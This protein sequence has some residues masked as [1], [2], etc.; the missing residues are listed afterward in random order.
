[1]KLQID[2]ELRELRLE[3]RVI[4]LYSDEAFSLLSDLWVSTG[5]NQR[6][7][8]TF[9]WLGVP[10]IQLP[11]DVIRYQ[12]VLY[13][14]RPDVVIE[15]GIA[16]GGSAILSASLLKL[17]GRGRVIAIDIDIRPQNRKRLKAHP[18][19]P[20]LTLIEGSSTAPQTL[21]R[22]KAAV[23]PDETVLVVLDSD[24]S[25]AHVMAELQAYAPLVNRGSYIVATDGVMRDLADTPRGE[26]HW[27]R[28]NPAQ[29]AID[30]VS[31]NPQF[32]IEQPSWPFNESTLTVNVTHWPSAWIRRL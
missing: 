21:D 30:F 4:S 19:S 29:A 3:D 16:H 25:Y 26:A 7:S 1:M 27:T 2:T 12:E 10:L 11:E 9:S 31:A 24:H 15:T 8:Y 28:D 18:L 13:R 5:W 14:L 22:V 20:L 6:Y 23:S 32:V 17:I